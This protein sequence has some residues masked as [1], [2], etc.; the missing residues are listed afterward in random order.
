ML[1]IGTQIR[2]MLRIYTDL[3]VADYKLPIPLTP[4]SDKLLVTSYRTLITSV[5]F[6]LLHPLPLL[7]N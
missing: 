4:F 5:I 6:L 7:P 3:S 2:R 1:R